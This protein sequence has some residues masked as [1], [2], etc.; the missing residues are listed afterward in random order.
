MQRVETWRK[1]I[2]VP[3][4]YFD[5]KK[6]TMSSKQKTFLNNKQLV[7][8][9]RKLLK[10][11][12]LKIKVSFQ[13]KGYSGNVNRIDVITS[14][15]QK[16]MFILKKDDEY[17]L[18][19]L[20]KN[21]LV[22]YSLNH[23][24]VFGKISIDS[25]PFILLQYIPYLKS[26]WNESHY[27]KAIE[28]LIKKDNI[29]KNNITLLKGLRFI[30]EKAKN[31]V[32][33]YIDL[34]NRGAK[35]KVHPII[36]T[37]FASSVNKKT[38]KYHEQFKLQNNGLLT[39]SHN[40]LCENNILFGKGSYKD[41]LYIIDWTYPSIGSI[42]TDLVELVKNT[43]KSLRAKLIKLYR[44]RIDFDEFEI[45]YKATKDLNDLSYLSWVIKGV[46]NGDLDLDK[47]NDFK[48][49]AKRVERQ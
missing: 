37:K 3:N 9:F 13:D 23:P 1:R 47:D 27:F 18:I 20:Y 22:P 32:N 16:L 33:D 42:C 49:L 26:P 48:T 11:E 44:S 7:N 2:A 6:I 46:L 12:V 17:D 28:W 14:D 35:E 19:G 29:L 45:T 38:K 40:D 21:V 36:T 31:Q 8:F 25:K 10:K 43:S 41:R 24:K 15:N 5:L 34:I 39:L 4:N 30:R